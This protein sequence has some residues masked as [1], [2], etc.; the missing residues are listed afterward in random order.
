MAA[1][2][3]SGARVPMSICAAVSTNK[4]MAARRLGWLHQPGNANE[5]EPGAI[6]KRMN[7]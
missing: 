4:A 3:G 5:K 6:F 7:R 1:L 2:A